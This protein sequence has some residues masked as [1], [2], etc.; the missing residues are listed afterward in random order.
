MCPV[1]SVTYVS[2]RSTVLAQRGC[3]SH[4]RKLGGLG[5]KTP[6]VTA[7][8]QPDTLFNHCRRFAGM[9]VPTAPSQSMQTSEHR[10]SGYNPP[11]ERY[12]VAFSDLL[13]R[14]GRAPLEDRQMD[15]LRESSP[16]REVTAFYAGDMDILDA[17]TVSIVE[18]R[19]VSDAG[20]KRAAQLA[21]D[22]VKAEV[23]IVSGL[24]KGVDTAA[25]TSAIDNG[26]HVA[27]VI[28]TPLDKALIFGL[29]PW[30]CEN[31][32]PLL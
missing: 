1:R 22:L 4:S 29:R 24:A 19:E 23:T 11:R 8:F 5:E 31:A 10:R 32:V 16:R 15:F 6:P 27:A 28:G 7:S 17:P 18:M 21:R 25:L 3:W 13:L 12:A 2:G 9:P 30:L 14:I 26:G 20:W